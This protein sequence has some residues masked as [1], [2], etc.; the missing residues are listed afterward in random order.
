MARQAQ[1]S[2]D[3]PKINYIMSLIRNAGIA[4]LVERNLAKVE[5]ESSRLFSRSK[6]MGKRQFNNAL[7]HFSFKN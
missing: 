3:E 7:S 4:Q 6:F 2:L 1:K 5:V